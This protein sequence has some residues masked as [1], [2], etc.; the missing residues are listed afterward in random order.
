MASPEEVTQLLIE[1]GQ[2]SRTAFDQ[3][4]PLVYAELR[5]IA[6]HYMGMQG[7]GHT[8]QT[9]ALINEAYL[10]LAGGPSKGWQNRA[11]FFGVAAKAMRHVLVDHARARRAVRRGGEIRLVPLKEGIEL[12]DE[13]L[14]DLVALDDSLTKLAS[15][16]RRQSDVVEMRY[17]GGLSVEETAQALEI[18][19]ETVMRDWRAAKAWL[20]AQLSGSEAAPEA[21]DGS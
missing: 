9:T 15:L 7:A 21:S 19:P 2:G 5:R 6:R 4:M 12:S 20:Y 18:S 10:R 11:H 16:S 1:C 8:L 3:L 13:R 17:F 14:A